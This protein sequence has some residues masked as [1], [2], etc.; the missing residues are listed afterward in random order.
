M[1]KGRTPNRGRRVGENLLTRWLREKRGRLRDVHARVGNVVFHI[2]FDGSSYLM[3]KCAKCGLCCGT[4]RYTAVLLTVGDGKRVTKALNYPGM[5]KF[6][7]EE[8]VWAEV[9]E[10]KEVWPLIGLPSVRAGYAGYY[11]KRFEGENEKTVNEPHSC[12]FLKDGLCSIYEARPV[13]CR[14][15][16]YTTYHEGGVVHAYYVYV[17]RSECPG[18]RERR[19]LKRQWLAPWVRDLLEGDREIAKSVKMGFFQII[20]L[21][22]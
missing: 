10:G 12:R 19:H 7:E 13:V 3:F 11:L 18:Y 16:P 17:P 8:C 20:G 6:L 1:P 15:F 9:S 2:P 5:T 22:E 21:E 14:K 4:Q